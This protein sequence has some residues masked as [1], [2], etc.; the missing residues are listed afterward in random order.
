M[1]GVGVGVGVIRARVRGEARARGGPRRHN[2]GPAA[3]SAEP[4]LQLPREEELRQL[5]W[6]RRSPTSAR[7]LRTAP[8]HGTPRRVTPRH[9]TPRHVAAV[10]GEPLRCKAEQRP[11]LHG[12][13]LPPGGGAGRELLAATVCHVCGLWQLFPLRWQPRVGTARRYSALG[14]RPSRH[15][16]RW[17]T[18]ARLGA[19]ATWSS[20]LLCSGHTS[21]SSRHLTLY[22]RAGGGGPATRTTR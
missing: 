16:G 3:P 18:T 6:V 19:A 12:G 5:T 7:H 13:L 21:S 22:T 20:T 9:V 17:R 4:P 8:S 11:P 1:Q 14:G 10:C 2:G 15:G